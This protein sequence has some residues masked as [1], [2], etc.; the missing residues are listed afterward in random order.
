MNKLYEEYGRL[1]V[2]A[3]II[4]G[5]INEVKRKIAEELNRGSVKGPASVEPP[6]SK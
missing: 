1:L 6:A 5:R 4:Q 2:D 3:E